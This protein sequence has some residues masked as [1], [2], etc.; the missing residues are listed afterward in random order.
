MSKEA[1][2]IP[3]PQAQNAHPRE[4]CVNKPVFPLR[5]RCLWEEADETHLLLVPTIQHDKA[6]LWL[7][8]ELAGPGYR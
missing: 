4:V 7:D 6:I 8:R 5:N 1:S 2:V 3:V